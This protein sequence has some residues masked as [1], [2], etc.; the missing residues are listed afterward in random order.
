M[1]PVVA[2]ILFT[3]QGSVPGD[4]QLKW[5]TG[6]D[7]AL[8][9]PGAITCCENTMPLSHQLG[10]RGLGDRQE[11][12]GCE[13]WSTTKATVPRGP[14]GRRRNP[15]GLQS[16]G[17][18]PAQPLPASDLHPILLRLCLHIPTLGLQAS[19]FRGENVK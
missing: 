12:G 13:H 5:A 10:W 15:L 18:C 7:A 6:G 19:K 1:S 2:I 8:G 11:N 17:C 16:A 3:H 4:M 14:G 9:L